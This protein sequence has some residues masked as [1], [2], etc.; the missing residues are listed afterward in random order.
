M[1]AEAALIL[2]FVFG[3]PEPVAPPP[4]PPVVKQSLTTRPAV[5]H[6]HTCPRCG[7]TWDHRENPGHQC[8]RCGTFQYV[9][10]ARPR[11]VTVIKR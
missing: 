11:P 4:K 3:S 2:A 1:N 8:V 7:T 6:T 9:Q 10:D 5:G